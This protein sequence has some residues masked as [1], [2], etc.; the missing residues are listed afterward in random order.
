MHAMDYEIILRKAYQ[1]GRGGADGE[2][3]ADIY[4][5]YE[6]VLRQLELQKEAVRKGEPRHSS[7]SMEDLEYEVRKHR[8]GVGNTLNGALKQTI[9]QFTERAKELNSMFFDPYKKEYSM[10]EINDRMASILT[11]QTELGLFPK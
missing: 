8:I 3:E 7:L 10:T 2:A 5:R 9:K 6:R 4:R 11:I 1:T